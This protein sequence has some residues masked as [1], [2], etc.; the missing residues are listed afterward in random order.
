[1]VKKYRDL[2]TLET[3]TG[4]QNGEDTSASLP[5]FE[6]MDDALHHHH[7][8]N[9]PILISSIHFD[10]VSHVQLNE[11]RTEKVVEEFLIED[12]PEFDCCRNDSSF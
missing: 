6:A 8:I 10:D 1:M 2:K 7:N 9:P 4:T 3:G 5:Y 12:D 11:Q